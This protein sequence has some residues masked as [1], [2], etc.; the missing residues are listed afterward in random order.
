MIQINFKSYFYKKTVFIIFIFF[1]F[2]LINGS[3]SFA[4]GLEV[5]EQKK[6][7]L[8]ADSISTSFAEGTAEK[9][10]AEGNA[11]MYYRA[12]EGEANYRIEADYIEYSLLTDDIYIKGNISFN[13][14]DYQ[15][16]TDKINGN[17]ERGL[18]EAVGD[19][20]LEGSELEIN[21][22]ELSVQDNERIM[23]FKGDVTLNYNE[24]KASADTVI[25]EPDK[26]LALLE[27]NVKGEN[28]EMK[29]S[30]DKM[31]LNLKNE[32]MKLL[33]KAEFLFKN[34]GGE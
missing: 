3:C 19:V 11:L 21:S 33:G 27:G 24:V 4:T 5:A 2:I 28:E 29:I 14:E 10:I 17:L 9:V 16:Y 30:G 18:F 20:L 8:W 7:G 23:V 6:E 34:E 1:T 31:E 26:D 13:N 22:V 25:Y 12:N 32:Q 15:L